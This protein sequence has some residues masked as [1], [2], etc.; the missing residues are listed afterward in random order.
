M[1]STKKAIGAGLTVQD[2]RGVDCETSM[3]ERKKLIWTGAPF[4]G[5][6][7]PPSCCYVDSSLMEDEASARQSRNSSDV[8]S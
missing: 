5:P 4:V 1:L 7:C 3:K 8:R 2:P 6:C